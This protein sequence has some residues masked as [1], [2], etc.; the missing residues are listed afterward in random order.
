MLDVLV[1][2]LTVEIIGL[3]ALPIAAIMLRPLPDR[4]YGASKILG[5]LL[6]GWLAY[7][8][9]MTKLVPFERWSL[10]VCLLV[11]A[12]LSLWLLL[13]HGRALLRE[14]GARFRTPRFVRYVIASEAL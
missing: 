14:F 12:A 11:V 8:L 10:F 7:L 13:R 1:W 4:G 5:L 2:W 3:V 6:A 9:A